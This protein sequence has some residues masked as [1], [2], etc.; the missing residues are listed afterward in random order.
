MVRSWEPMWCYSLILPWYYRVMAWNFE[1]IYHITIALNKLWQYFNWKGRYIFYINWLYFLNI[2]DQYFW[3]II[4]V[5]IFWYLKKLHWFNWWF[6][7][8]HMYVII[9]TI[10]MISS[11]QNAYILYESLAGNQR[12]TLSKL[13]W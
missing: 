1:T 5:V 8:Y 13:F 2:S 3:N 9:I 4:N 7:K 10:I 11:S 12:N 6:F